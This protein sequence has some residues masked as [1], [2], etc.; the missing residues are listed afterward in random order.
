V[1]LRAATPTLA[2]KAVPPR[3]PAGPTDAQTR[4][5]D[6]RMK[7]AHAD[8]DLWKWGV[9][10]DSGLVKAERWRGTKCMWI[11]SY[12]ADEVARLGDAWPAHVMATLG[13]AWAPQFV[14]GAR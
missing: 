1:S 10:H 14:R 12:A 4:D 7:A 8:G 3:K 11:V 6:A 5:L 2:R 13:Y 9:S